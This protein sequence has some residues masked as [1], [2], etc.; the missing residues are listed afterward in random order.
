MSSSSSSRIKPPALRPDDTVGIVAPASNI[1]RS[2]LEAGCE[3]LRRAGYRP[4]YSES[5]FDHDLF[6]AGSVERRARELEAMFVRDD[7]RLFARA[8]ATART[9]CSKRWT[10][11]RLRHTPRFSSA[12]A[13]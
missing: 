12:I 2:D 7:G 5:I 13:M 10:G 9:I 4:I 3:G 11:R 1:K 6:F 8:A